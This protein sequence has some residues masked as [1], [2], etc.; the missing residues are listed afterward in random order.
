MIASWVRE[1]LEAAEFN[2]RR[3]T[4]RA[5]IIG[6]A[7]GEHMTASIPAAC[8]GYAELAAAYRFCDNDKVTLELVIAPHVESTL[9]R[10][11]GQ[12]VV[13]L[14]QDTTE[15]DLSRPKQQVAGAGPM[16][17]SSRRGVFLQIGRAH[18]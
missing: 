14:V 7:L 10:I 15:L 8:G 11:R 3:L 17:G 5:M 2:D 18:V 16:D 6:S 4:K 13:L 12:S 1:E 9:R